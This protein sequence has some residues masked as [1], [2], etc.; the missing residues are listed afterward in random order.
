M[1]PIESAI[2]IVPPNPDR[3]IGF[4]MVKITEALPLVDELQNDTLS[5]YQKRE[6]AQRLLA[7]LSDAK[8]GYE[9]YMST[10]SIVR[11]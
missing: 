8:V 10:P 7:I 2:E 9:R 6:H 3:L 4:L 5:I 11:K 1:L